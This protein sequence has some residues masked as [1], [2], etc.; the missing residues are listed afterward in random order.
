MNISDAIPKRA[1]GN[2]LSMYSIALEGWRRG[3]TLKFYNAYHNG[4]LEIQYSLSDQEVVHK[5]QISKGDQVSEQAVEICKDKDL[6]KKYL[7]EA[8]VTVPEG[9]SFTEEVNNDT[10]LAYAL[11][12][13]F[14]IVIKPLDGKLGRGVMLNIQTKN[15]L[16]EK[17]QHVRNELGFHAVII[18]KY[19]TGDD[20]RVYVVD[21]RVIGAVKRIP[22]HVVGDGESTIE[23]LINEKNKE[24]KNNPNLST[25]LIT[26]DNHALSILKEKGYTLDSVL[27][28]GE[29]L[30]L[31]DT[32]NI[33]SGGEPVD[34]TNQLTEEM[35]QQAINSLK[36]IPGLP[37]AGVDMIVDEMKGTS[38]V[39]EVNTRAGI[40]SHLFPVTGEARNIPKAIIDYYFPNSMQTN[41]EQANVNYLFDFKK[42]TD[43]LRAGK[44]NEVVIPTLNIEEK[45]ITDAYEVYGDVQT[46]TYKNWVQK[47]ALANK[48]SGYTIDLENGNALIV[49]AGEEN[50][51]NTFKQVIQSGS[52]IM[53]N[54]TIMDLNPYTNGPIEYG[55][56]INVQ[57]QP[58]KRNKKQA[59]KQGNQYLRQK[60]AEVEKERKKLETAKKKYSNLLNSKSWRYTE[61]MRKVIKKM[62]NRS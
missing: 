48:I 60:K 6:T 20:Y 5:F 58:K 44:V 22:A 13:G 21:N 16:L 25:R 61:P 43:H 36:A 18:E 34:V 35:K 56:K 41:E 11:S 30:F 10:I 17:L 39:I 62:K 45:H 33:S 51:L 14:P 1:H 8:G 55:F 40:G 37:Q 9:K 47:Q 3:L 50:N 42:V 54:S 23:S 4:N 46:T 24:R 15:E 59:N 57:V 49:A 2:N 27:T 38:Y 26:V 7:L 52:A 32:A 28:K 53:K 29:Y 19:V 31:K 12:I